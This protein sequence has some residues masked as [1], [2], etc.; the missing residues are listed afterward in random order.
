[1]TCRAYGRYTLR[2]TLELLANCSLAITPK[3]PSKLPAA[4]LPASPCSE[5][6]WPPTDCA[7]RGVLLVFR[8]AAHPRDPDKGGITAQGTS[9]AVL[10]HGT[11]RLRLISA[12]AFQ[13]PFGLGAWWL[14][15]K[16][17]AAASVPQ[18]CEATPERILHSRARQNSLSHCDQQV[19]LSPQ[20]TH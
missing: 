3:R 5:L 19:K 1:M 2:L 17:P 12:W 20:S 7:S 8:A 10:P 9:L 15:E 11:D 4:V 6:L 18:A 13:R 16:V 14:E